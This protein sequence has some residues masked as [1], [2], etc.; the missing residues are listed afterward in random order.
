MWHG[1]ENFTEWAIYMIITLAVAGGLT[2]LVITFNE[3]LQ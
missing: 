1:P 3:V 2:T